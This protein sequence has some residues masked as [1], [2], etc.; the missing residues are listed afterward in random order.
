VRRDLGFPVDSFDL[1]KTVR[2]RAELLEEFFGV[3]GG[4]IGE[5]VEE[6]LDVVPFLCRDDCFQLPMYEE[7]E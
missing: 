1:E 5:V 6:R 7:C 4:V 3:S 2:K